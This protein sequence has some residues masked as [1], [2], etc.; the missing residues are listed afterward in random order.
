MQEQEGIPHPPDVHLGL[1]PHSAFPPSPGASDTATATGGTLAAC[2]AASSD[3]DSAG[4]W[5]LYQN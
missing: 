2:A 1:Q 3:A 5:T 4:G